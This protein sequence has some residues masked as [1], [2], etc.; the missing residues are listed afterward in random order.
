MIFLPFTSIRRFRI[1]GLEVIMKST[2]VIKVFILIGL[3]TSLALARP[4]EP[5]AQTLY[6]LVHGI[7][8]DE[9]GLQEWRCPPDYAAG[10][11]TWAKK[12]LTRY[13]NDKIL[14]SDHGSYT[15][16]FLNPSR[17]PIELARELADRDRGYTDLECKENSPLVETVYD[18]EQKKIIKQ[19]SKTA[20]SW[21]FSNVFDQALKVWFEQELL[22][23]RIQANKQYSNEQEYRKF[24]K[25]DFG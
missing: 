5:A 9:Y 23:A 25:W 13:L 10:G 14:N 24:G 8:P 19:G 2:C 4:M 16:T 7:N 6:I 22:E 3:F 1:L 18:A 15:Q 11:N 20:T 12:G 17:S 21:R